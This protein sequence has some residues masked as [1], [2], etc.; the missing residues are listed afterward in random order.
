MISNDTVFYLPNNSG[1]GDALQFSKHPEF[2]YNRFNEKMKLSY[3]DRFSIFEKNPFVIIDNT[4]IPTLNLW[5]LSVPHKCGS[6]VY[7]HLSELF[8]VDGVDQDIK[9][10]MYRVEVEKFDIPTIAICPEASKRYQL[11]WTREIPPSISNHIVESLSGKFRFIQVGGMM[12]YKIDGCYDHRGLSIPDMHDKISA[13]E[14]L[15]CLNS[16]AMHV[17]ACTNTKLFMYTEFPVANPPWESD[18]K[19]YTA[20]DWLYHSTT[21]IGPSGRDGVLPIGKFIKELL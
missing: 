3:V 20:N 7:R 6:P 13:C 4:I 17:G 21:Y 5:Q 10:S 14:A 16:G 15:I 8:N 2:F 9:P 11:G 18:M 12:D 19:K 1:I